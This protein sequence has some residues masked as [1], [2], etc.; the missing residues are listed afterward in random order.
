MLGFSAGDWIEVF[1]A[2]LLMLSAAL[3]APGIRAKIVSLA[4]RPRVA[5][6][7]LFAA[8]IVLRLLLLPHHPVPK[9]RIYDEFS[10]LLVADTLRHFR[11]A[12]PAHPMSRFFETFFVLQEP[13]YSSIYPLGQGLMLA[14]G[15]ALTGSAWG[16]VLAM[17]GLFCALSYWML[18][19]FVEARWALAGG[20]LAVIEFGPLNLWTNCY[21]GGLLAG[22]AGCLVFGSL[23]RL[24]SAWIENEGPRTR[25][26]VLLGLGFSLH[27]L[28]RQFETVLL[29]LTILLFLVWATPWRRV[30]RLGLRDLR[31]TAIPVLCAGVLIVCQ[32]H[33][34]TGRFGTLPEQ[35]SQWQYGVPTTL[36]IEKPAVPH[37]ALTREQEMEYRSQ[38]LMHGP[39]TDSVGKFMARLEY[40][41]RDYRFFV[42]PPLYLALGIFLWTLRSRLSQWILGTLLI[43][44]CGTN[45]FPYLLVHYLAGITSLF[46]LTAILGLRAISRWRV[47]Q[48][49]VGWQIVHV[50]LL[51]CGGQFLLWYT[52]HLFEGNHPALN[53]LQYE[54]WD[55]IDHTQ[56]SPHDRIAEQLAAMP[57]QLLVL[58]H[59][60]PTHVFQDEWVWNAADIDRSRVVRARDLGAAD[61]AQLIRYYPRRRVLRL[62]PDQRPAQLSDWTPEHGEP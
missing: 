17:G 48:L 11:L 2:G 31:Y 41:A 60:A 61:D 23:A 25:E 52:L 32:N 59:Y 44:G 35:L 56:M 55:Y 33:A 45:L 42:L 19:G 57:G 47:S 13:T 5:M 8:P 6:A 27:A 34:V 49:A 43:F 15:K 1:F 39:G 20:A 24:R 7:V 62:D 22:V 18:G 46:L 40:R 16:G 26:A 10:H 4:E 36:T 38:F 50:A 21:W 29:G 54:T 28:T 3:W 9:P 14:L 30:W 12:N 58:V 37:R 51:L 53:L